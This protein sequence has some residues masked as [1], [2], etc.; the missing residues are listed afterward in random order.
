MGKIRFLLILLVV[1]FVFE[2]N[3]LAASGSLSVSSEN[4]Y[5]GDS[6]TVTAN[7][8]SAAAWNVHVSASGPVSNCT[9]N[10]AN[11]TDDALDTNKTFSATC[12][13]TGEGTINI[14]LSGDVTSASDGNAVA[15]SE[16]KNVIV[17]SK[18]ILTPDQ[19]PKP[20]PNPTPTPSNNDDKVDDRSKNNN[21]KELS[22]DGYKVVKVDNNNY[23]LTVSNDVRSIKVNAISEDTKATVTGSGNQE[24]NVGDNNIEIV[25]TS[26]SGIPNKINLKVTRKD[27]YYLEDLDDVLKNDK[28]NNIKINSDTKISSKEMDKIKNNKKVI[29]FDYYDENNTLLYS[30][31]IDG[32]KDNKSSDLLTTLVYDSDNK[33]DIE[34]ISN[35]VDGLYLSFK[36]NKIPSEIKV[37]VFVGNKYIDN[38]IINVYSYDKETNK[39]NYIQSDIKVVNGY[40]EFEVDTDTNYLLTKADLSSGNIKVVDK[41]TSNDNKNINNIYKILTYLFGS[42]ITI[43]IIIIVMK[44]KK[45]NKKETIQ[46]NNLQETSIEENQEDIL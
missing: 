13:A 38:D 20:Q 11:A 17:T 18:P 34:K 45:N 36:Q 21:L 10:Q 30:I 25:I 32:T 39:L 1:S 42:I 29:S 31:I 15:I 8:N 7:I 3:V 28:V 2:V 6:F 5:I 4:V 14:V 24:L 27:G 41:K 37:K 9:I 12:I 23:T 40:I 43:E 35:Y 22:V 44:K 26:E 46:I 33:K 19:T 16:S